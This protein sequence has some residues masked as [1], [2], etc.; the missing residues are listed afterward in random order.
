MSREMV[1]R[2]AAPLSRLSSDHLGMRCYES[3]PRR[4]LTAVAAAMTLAVATAQAQPTVT[5]RAATPRTVWGDPELQGMWSNSTL[6]P[7]ERPRG[8]AD[9]EFLSQEEVDRLEQ[10]AIDR[11]IRL[12]N[13]PSLRTEV[14]A[15]VDQGIDG[16]PGSFNDHWWERGTTVVPTRRT[17]LITVPV[18]GRLPPLTPEM[19]ARMTSPDAQRIA[20][21]RGGRRPTDSWEQL[22]LRV[23]CIWYRGIPTFPTG[24]N[25]NY[26]F[27]QTPEHVAIVQEHI[28][29]VRFIPIDDR[30]HLTPG[31]RQY[32]G[33]SRGRWDGQTLV[34]DTT[35][36]N[37]RAFIRRFN[38]V[39]SEALHVVERFT[40]VSPDRLDYQ[41]TVTDPN[42]WTRS[43]TG[44]L[45]YRRI[46]GPLFEYACHEGNYGLTNILTGSRAQDR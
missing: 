19:H 40:R 11:Q 39:L 44:A 23:R 13:R 14:G 10:A 36:F 20:D 16:A 43:W 28:H 1:L 29:D 4:V 37:D 38:G 26:Q 25:D 45:S 32:S 7:L 2:C 6:T 30:P 8:Q 17:S 15:S 46:P 3:S 9:R 5:E 12:A 34:V 18:D 31:I 35:N 42:T 24:Y 33:D 22:D 21:V 41:F 27:I